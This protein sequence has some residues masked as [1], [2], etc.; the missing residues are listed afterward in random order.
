LSTEQN[1]YFVRLGV[2]G[3][4]WGLG[5]TL[6]FWELFYIIALFLGNG[7]ISQ[8]LDSVCAPR[9]NKRGGLYIRRAVIYFY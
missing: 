7:I 3:F 6:W 5:A 9:T 2:D 8:R 1:F 4:L